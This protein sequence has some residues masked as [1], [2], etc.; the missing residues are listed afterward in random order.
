[1]PRTHTGHMQSIQLLYIPLKKI[2]KIENIIQRQTYIQLTQTN[3]TA[4]VHM[5]GKINLLR[6]RSFSTY[7]GIT[8]LR[9]HIFDPTLFYFT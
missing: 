7:C 3:A 9:E 8:G 6:C 4:S 5:T 2:L 1:M